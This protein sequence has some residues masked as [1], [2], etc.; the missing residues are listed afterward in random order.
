MKQQ[1]LDKMLQKDFKNAALLLYEE[2]LKIQVP[3]DINLNITIDREQNL[4]NITIKMKNIHDKINESYEEIS[5]ENMWIEVLNTN[6]FLKK[7]NLK[8]NELLLKNAKTAYNQAMDL[9]RKQHYEQYFDG[10][11][12]L[13]TTLQGVINAAINM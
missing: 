11:V 7:Q 9:I 12:T 1:F 5:F 8:D 2:I 10:A 13:K 4:E 3:P 6:E